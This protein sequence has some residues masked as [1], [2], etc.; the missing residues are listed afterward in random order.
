M[1]SSGDRAPA[2]SSRWVARQGFPVGNPCL[3][4]RGLETAPVGPGVPRLQE[5]REPGEP[6]PNHSCLAQ[7]SSQS[8]INRL[9]RSLCKVQHDKAQ[10]A[11]APKSCPILGSFPVRYKSSSLG[12]TETF[13]AFIFSCSHETSLFLFPSVTPALIA[14]PA[15]TNRTACYTPTSPATASLRFPSSL[16]P[17]SPSTFL[18]SWERTLI[19]S[20]DRILQWTVGLHALPS[21][22][23]PTDSSTPRSR[24]STL[25]SCLEDCLARRRA[26]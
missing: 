21:H 1:S 2:S 6:G 16:P 25:T 15:P 5:P 23:S 4:W 18:T 8:R 3:W 13:S 14:F 10:A 20:R 9:G 19:A 24:P 11:S 17:T 7:Q 12:P 22:S 26:S